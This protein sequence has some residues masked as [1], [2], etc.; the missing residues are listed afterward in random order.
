LS[1]H[2]FVSDAHIGAAPAGA[3]SRLVE[4][5]E[6]IRGRATSLYVLGDLFDFWFEY[7]RAIPVSGF[8][9][10]GALS[11]LAQEGTR[12]VYLAGNHDVRFTGFFKRE[13]GIESC[14]GPLAE[15]LDGRRV[16]MSHGDDLDK[17]LIPSLFR[18]LM[19]SR[20]NQ[21]LYSL[22]HPD[23]GISL[24]RSVSGASRKRPPDA[25]LAEKMAA[26]ARTRLEQGQD[27]VVLAHLHRPELRT[28]GSGIYLNTGD[29]VS[30]FSYGKLEQG[31]LSLEFWR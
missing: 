25:R 15:T 4:F 28:F 14:A 9:V 6:S 10:L 13:L 24:A 2:Y 31:R 19:R 29:W 18:T 3:E 16:W 8:R 21:A 17:R 20:V 1:A 23:L 26:F 30:N 27:I 7:N 5:L 12:V 22:V 11:R